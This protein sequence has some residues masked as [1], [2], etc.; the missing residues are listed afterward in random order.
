MACAISIERST[1][2]NEHGLLLIL[3][4]CF[5]MEVH[6]ITCFAKKSIE[7][8]YIN[9]WPFYLYCI[10]ESFWHSKSKIEPTLLPFVNIEC[11]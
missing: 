11:I 3:V 1:F 8:H 2:A 10:K 6:L 5:S 9:V 7:V 4:T